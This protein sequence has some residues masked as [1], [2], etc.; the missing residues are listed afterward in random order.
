MHNKL[1]Q[2]KTS[3]ARQWAVTGLLAI[4]TLA[5]SVETAG[6]Q[7]KVASRVEG[8]AANQHPL[9]PAIRVAQSSREALNQV[10]DYEA[11]F[12]KRELIGKR[13][14]T[15]TTTIR[16]REEPFSVYLKFQ[17]PNAGREV[18]YV[19]GRNEGKMLVHEV[20]VKSLVGTLALSPSG[21]EVMA[22]NR[23]PLTKVGIAN[24][25]DTLI[26]QW[27]MESKYGDVDVKYFPNAKL[28]SRDCKVIQTTQPQPQRHA[29]FHITRLYIDRE[30]NLPIRAEQYGF[31]QAPGQQPDLIEEYT[32]ANIR[33]NIGLTDLHFDVKNP[34]YGF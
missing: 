3:A 8:T 13:I 18:I 11:D 29:K 9:L 2:R 15:Q 23:Y 16:F 19:E 5:L 7:P 27:Q 12:T 31:P 28:G 10:K 22:E 4:G 33:T 32:Y 24:M 1:D 14:Q 21:N 30:T 34:E 25:V 26:E 20:G 6:A 17:K